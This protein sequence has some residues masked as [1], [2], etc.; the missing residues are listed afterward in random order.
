M[1]QK[2]TKKIEPTVEAEEAA[3]VDAKEEPVMEA[4]DADEVALNTSHEE[5]KEESTVEVTEVAESKEEREEI[6]EKEEEKSAETE[7]S[8]EEEAV[9][10][11]PSNEEEAVL[12]EPKEENET[13]K[14]AV[15]KSMNSDTVPVSEEEDALQT[16]DSSTDIKKEGCLPDLCDVNMNFRACFA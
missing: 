10:A 13:H 3:P 6:V 7:P 16:K 12:A 4:R 5:A 2:F 11:E 14:E 1:S 8:S 15:E 9:P